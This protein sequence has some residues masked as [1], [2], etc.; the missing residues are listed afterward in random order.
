M[1]EMQE[2]HIRSLG[3]EDPLEK[4][5]NPFQYSCLEDTVDSRAWRAAAPGVSESHATEHSTAAA[6]TKAL[7]GR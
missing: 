6:I 1:Q 2:A 7:C 3:R 4:D 5:G